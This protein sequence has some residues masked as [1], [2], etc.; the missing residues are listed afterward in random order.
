MCLAIRRRPR[1]RAGGGSRGARRRAPAWLTTSTPQSVVGALGF[2]DTGVVPGHRVSDQPPYHTAPL[3]AGARAVSESKAMGFVEGL[4][5][6]RPGGTIRPN[7]TEELLAGRAGRAVCG[8]SVHAAEP[9][10]PGC[11]RAGRSRVQRG[12]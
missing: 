12:R 1:V 2:I 6:G 8:L 5:T 4:L 11:S 10:A 7:P 3:G 9:D